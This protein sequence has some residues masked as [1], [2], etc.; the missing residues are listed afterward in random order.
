M[1][2]VV[3]NEQSISIILLLNEVCQGLFCL[4]SWTP[5]R[6]KHDFV[7]REFIVLLKHLSELIDLEATISLVPSLLS[8][9]L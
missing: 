2:S 1:A 6:V 5:S 8:T 4:K 3:Y 7:D 9:V